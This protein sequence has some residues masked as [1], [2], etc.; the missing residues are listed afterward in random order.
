MAQIVGRLIEVF[1]TFW[2]KITDLFVAKSSHMMQCFLHKLQI[3]K[4]FV[5]DFC[6]FNVAL[7]YPSKNQF[8]SSQVAN[9]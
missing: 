2:C 1:S 3:P 6:A 9:S 7:N 5:A 8:L 4:R